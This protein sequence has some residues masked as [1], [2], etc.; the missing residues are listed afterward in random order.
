MEIRIKPLHQIAV[1][2]SALANLV[3]QLGY[4]ASFEDIKERLAWLK[5]STQDFIFFAEDE[6]ANLVGFIHLQISRNL[7]QPA[8][9]QIVAL[10]VDDKMRGK[11]V[12]RHL[13]EI[14][15]N[16]AKEQKVS[17]IWLR[18]GAHRDR[19][20]KF[21]ESLGYIRKTTSYKYIKELP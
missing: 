3:G 12:G 21:Y 14:A 8:F 19:A 9:L 2:V 10:V 4:P 15:E 5:N 1:D 18:T 20:H 11:S 17:L 7:H 13:I 6:K 16:Y